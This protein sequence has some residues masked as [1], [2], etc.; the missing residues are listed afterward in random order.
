MKCKSLILTLVLVAVFLTA[1]LTHVRAQ[2]DC[3]KFKATYKPFYWLQAGFAN[4]ETEVENSTFQFRRARFGLKGMVCE[5]IGYHLMIEGIH[6]GFAPKVYQAWIDYEFSPLANIRV[7]QFKYPFGIE[8]YPGFIWWKFI[9]PSYVTTGIVKE[10]GRINLGDE[11]GLLRDI[12]V[13]LSGIHEFNNDLS[14]LYKVMLMNGNGI[15]KTDNNDRKDIVVRGI[16]QT[17]GAKFGLSYYNGSFRPTFG[18]ENYGEWA[19]G[20][21]FTWVHDVNDNVFRFQAELITASYET[22]L[23]DIKPW[24]YYFYGTWTAIPGPEIGLRFDFYEEDRNDE[25]LSERKRITLGAGYY[26]SK[27]NKVVINYE[28][29]DDDVYDTDNLLNAI[30]QIAL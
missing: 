9:T 11:S 10:L 16:L 20:G 18:P 3:T 8:A 15:N 29:I 27:G 23:D 22:I 2:K 25:D 26:F 6:G 14:A 1:G 12:G 19:L 13:Q 21:D 7:G 28:L 17:P 24:G 5:K 4:E 30:F